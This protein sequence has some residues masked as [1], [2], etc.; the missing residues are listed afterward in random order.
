MHNKLLIFLNDGKILQNYF[1]YFFNTFINSKLL[2][3]MR[4]FFV[5]YILF[6][7]LISFR[8]T[9]KTCFTGNKFE[10]DVRANRNKFDLQ[11][12]DTN[13]YKNVR[14]H[15]RTTHTK[16]KHINATTQRSGSQNRFLMSNVSTIPCF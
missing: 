9:T 4:L 11:S 13:T 14:V 8:T 5:L 7:L 3:G 2:F 12:C 15:I 1:N 10:T 16:R 6:I